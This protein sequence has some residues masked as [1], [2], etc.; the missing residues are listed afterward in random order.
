MTRPARP[1]RDGLEAVV[2]TL[3][4]GLVAGYLLLDWFTHA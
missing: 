1:S 2:L 4:V 3:L